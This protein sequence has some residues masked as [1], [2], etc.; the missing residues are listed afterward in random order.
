[1]SNLVLVTS[2]S[3]IIN[4]CY[5]SAIARNRDV[6]DW[7]LITIL[8]FE[9]CDCIF[10]VRAWTASVVV[11]V[12]GMFSGVSHSTDCSDFVLALIL[13]EDAK[14]ELFIGCCE[15]IVRWYVTFLVVVVIATE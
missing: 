1:M 7:V 13:V 3:N 11:R 8:L 10:N 15:S 2:A 5:Y 4:T 9:G 14:H 6:L 12:T